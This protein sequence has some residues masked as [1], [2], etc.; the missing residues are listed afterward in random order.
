M[1]DQPITAA[2]FEGLAAAAGAAPSLHNSQPWRFRPTPDARGLQ[3]YAD[4][5]RAVPLADP[6]GRARTVSVGAAVL[7]LRV[8]AGRLGRAAD[9]RLLPE[10]AEPDLMAVLD[11]SAPGPALDPDL[12]AAIPH[13]HSG[14]RPFANRDVPEAVIE[15][16]I[17]AAAAEGAVLTSLEEAG[18]R[19][20]LTL[21]AQAE[22]RIAADPARRAEHRSW[23]RTDAPAD[24]GIPAS[25]LGP[26]DRDDRVP[27]RDFAGDSG[28]LPPERFE[29]LPQLCTLTT[30]GDGPVDWLRAGQALEHLWLLAT[31]R[32]VRANVLHQAVEFPDTRLMLRDPAD[33]PG[34]VQ[35]VLRLGYGPPGAPTPRRPVREILDL[36]TL[37]G[38]PQLRTA[39]PMAS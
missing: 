32:G 25:A 37:P 24:E 10:P 6:E 39:A 1:F 5:A 14:R 7:N 4:P 22:R 38:G 17:A 20:V 11:L 18:V 35:L 36:S 33:S 23:I 29:A 13:R 3:V 9:V 34:H 16:L 30:P 2:E 27:M 28:P 8:A 31:V 12:S 19:S 15:E 26:M 21:T